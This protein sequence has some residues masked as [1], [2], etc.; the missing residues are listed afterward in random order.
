[1]SLGKNIFMGIMINFLQLGV[2][3]DDIDLDN[4]ILYI[5]I[6]KESYAYENE[7][8]KAYHDADT[9][10]KRIKEVWIEMGIFPSD[11]S[12]KYKTKDIYWTK[13]MGN[14][15][16]KENI[17]RIYDRFIGGVIK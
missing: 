13:E 8:N 2:D 3:I 4:H 14:R 11:C 9:Y 5:T 12:V 10:A 16:Y 17:E 7:A 6:P 1:M 15:N